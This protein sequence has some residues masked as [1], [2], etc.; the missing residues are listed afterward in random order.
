MLTTLSIKAL[1]ILII[2]LLNSQSDN[3][4]SLP[5][6]NLIL[7]LALSLQTVEVF[8]F[9]FWLHPD[10]WSSRARDQIQAAV[11]TQATAVAMLDP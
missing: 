5:Q 3:P 2:V 11:V 4:T 10:T 1:S 8:C 9:H 7:M 6:L